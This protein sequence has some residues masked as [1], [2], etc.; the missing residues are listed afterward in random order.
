MMTALLVATYTASV[1]PFKNKILNT[2]LLINDISITVIAYLLY[3]YTEM[4]RDISDLI[5]LGWL[6]VFLIMVII[7]TNLSIISFVCS[8]YIKIRCKLFLI[9][10]KAKEEYEK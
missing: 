4:F 8:T 3:G 9:Q 6:G 5:A 2:S 10:I 7:L 1:R